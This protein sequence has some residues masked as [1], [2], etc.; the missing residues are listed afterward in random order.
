MLHYF[1]L[2]KNLF[3]LP[4][5]IFLLFPGISIFLPSIQVSQFRLKQQKR[6]SKHMK[7]L[8][9]PLSLNLVSSD[10]WK[11]LRYD[12]TSLSLLSI[13]SLLL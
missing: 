10:F 11:Y 3:C 4:G 8:D 9:K 6:S 2:P 13:H 7:K 12:S 5:S 1:H